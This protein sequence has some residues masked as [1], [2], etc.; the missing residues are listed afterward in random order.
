MTWS[1][2][3]T[4]SLATSRPTAPTFVQIHVLAYI[5]TRSVQV[6]G[7]TLA[8]TLLDE[9]PFCSKVRMYHCFL[10]VSLPQ[11]PPLVSTETKKGRQMAYR[12][13][14]STPKQHP[15]TNLQRPIHSPTLLSCL[16]TSR[17][18]PIHR[19][20]QDGDS[21]R[22]GLHTR[23]DLRKLIGMDADIVQRAGRRE[24]GVR[25]WCEVCWMAASGVMACDAQWS[26]I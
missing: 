24:F 9:K 10:E 11:L 13:Q 14:P 2:N 3:K 15:P 16:G 12:I 20:H 5:L 7:G 4:Y 18:E 19:I 6:P 22:L 25:S 8:A 1:R 17:R 26:A 21:E 23:E